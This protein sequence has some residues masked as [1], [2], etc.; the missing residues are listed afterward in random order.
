[1]PTLY[2]GT[3]TR[4]EGHVDGHAKGIYAYSFDGRTGALELLKVTEGAGINPSYVLGTESMLSVTV[5]GEDRRLLGSFVQLSLFFPGASLVVP[6]RQDASHIH[7]TAWTPN[8]LVAADLGTDRVVQYTLDAESQKL[9]DEEF[10]VRPPRSGPRHFALSS[11]LGVAY[12]ICELDNTVGVHPLGVKTG[13]VGHE[14]LQNISTLP[15]N[16][17]GPAP[18]ASNIHISTNQRFVCAATRFSD[19]ITV[20]KIL[21]DTRLELVEYV[22]TCNGVTLEL[23][24]MLVYMSTP[25]LRSVLA[26]LKGFEPLVILTNQGRGPWCGGVSAIHVSVHRCVHYILA[27]Y[28]LGIFYLVLHIVYIS[29]N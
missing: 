3:Y 29:L 28:E 12:I 4:K 8:G 5:S 25:R 7:S 19:T 14:V 13:K 9:V 24:I 11:T 16:Y 27:R 26:G 23:H 2:V 6:D 15:P 22:S 21:A 10:I 20:Y 1:M 17:A 18:L